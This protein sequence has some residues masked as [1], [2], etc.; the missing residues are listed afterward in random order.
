MVAKPR[1]KRH[2]TK[3]KVLLKKAVLANDSPEK[4]ARG[5]A[6]GVFFGVL[7]TFGLA[8]IFSL[9]VA[10]VLKANRLTA[11]LGTFVSNPFTTPFYMLWATKIG[12]FI[13]QSGGLTFSWDIFRLKK[14]LLISKSLLVGSLVLATAISFLS[15][16]L[17][18]LLIPMI[19]KISGR[20][21]RYLKKV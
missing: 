10:V 21:D 6:I 8:A 1:K 13:L 20:S 14:L 18:I 9:P 4:L 17:L 3:F 2:L 7:P 19:R 16:G 5:F 15:Y 11:I 12:D